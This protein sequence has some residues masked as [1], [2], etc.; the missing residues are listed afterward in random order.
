[1]DTETGSVTEAVELDLER[2]HRLKSSWATWESWTT[3]I[4]MSDH[5]ARR[6]V[7]NFAAAISR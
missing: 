4:V 7:D 3:S 2:I 6:Y 5:D 1:M